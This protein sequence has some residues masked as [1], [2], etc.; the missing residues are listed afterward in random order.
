M[1]DQPLPPLAVNSGWRLAVR[2]PYDSPRVVRAII[3]DLIEYISVNYFLAVVDDSVIGQLTTIIQA[4]L[5]NVG[6]RGT[7]I[8]RLI[9]MAPV[10]VRSANV[11]TFHFRPLSDDGRWLLRQMDL[12]RDIPPVPQHIAAAPEVKRVVDL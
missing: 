1:D 9:E 6:F 2:N 8:N 12:L 10:Y 5:D 4:R 11:L 3:E 7:P